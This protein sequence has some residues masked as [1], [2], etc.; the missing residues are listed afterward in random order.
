MLLSMKE[1]EAANKTLKRIRIEL[2]LF[3][4]EKKRNI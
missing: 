1:N 3:C 4:N 2:N